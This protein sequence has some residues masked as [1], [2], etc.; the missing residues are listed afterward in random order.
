VWSPDGKQ[1][2]YISYNNNEFDL[3]LAKITFNTKTGKYSLQGNPVQLTTG[4][5]DGNSRPFWTP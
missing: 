4:G 3:W 5:I 2:A 1:I